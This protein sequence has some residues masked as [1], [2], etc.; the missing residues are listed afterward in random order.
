MGNTGADSGSSRADLSPHTQSVWLPTGTAHTLHLDEA[1]ADAVGVW[2][3]GARVAVE[4]GFDAAG[5]V[6][7]RIDGHV[8]GELDESAGTQLAPSLRMLE[9]RGL[10]AL[11]HGVFSLIDDTPAITIHA[12]PL[13]PVQAQAA[14]A[15][16]EATNETE[17]VEPAAATL[18]DPN[19]FFAAD[20][21]AEAAAL[22]ADAAGDNARNN[23]GMPGLPSRLNMQ[24]AAVLAAAIALGTVGVLAYYTSTGELAREITAYVDDSTTRSKPTASSSTPSSDEETE[25]A[26]ESTAEST[27]ETAGEE[28]T[29]AEPAPAR[30][31]NAPAPVPAPA[32][33]P[34][35][36][37]SN[38]GNVA[39]RPP[40]PRPSAPPAPVEEAPAQPAPQQNPN[41]PAPIPILEL[42]W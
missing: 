25:S 23:S 5:E 36:P 30:N 8:L 1:G 35:Q 29:P 34:A 18:S 14:A 16:A 31:N 21:E 9:S 20:K 7:A 4:V 13:A 27:E 41:E 15:S 19:V 3:D 40:A 10:I 38:Q 28:P 33:A 17:A 42:Q 6:V 11:A 22:A 24:L 26:T 12:D 37:R 32:P 2:T 39:P